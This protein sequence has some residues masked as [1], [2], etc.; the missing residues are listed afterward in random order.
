[1]ALSFSRSYRSY[2]PTRSGFTEEEEAWYHQRRGHQRV[3]IVRCR[4]HL[5]H[6]QQIE[7]IPSSYLDP[8]GEIRVVVVSGRGRG[9]ESA[10]RS[11]P[12]HLWKHRT[13]EGER[14]RVRVS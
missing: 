6:L 10:G 7:D 11:I 5:D 14:P 2:E 9:R 12:L 13:R 3:I 4:E 1:M 8:F